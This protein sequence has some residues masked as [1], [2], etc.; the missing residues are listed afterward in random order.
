VAAGRPIQLKMTRL[1]AEGDPIPVTLRADEQGRVDVITDSTQDIYGG[2]MVFR[3]TCTGP[4]QAP[5]VLG[6]THCSE[7]TPI[8]RPGR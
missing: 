2:Q 3:Q 1:T 7:P 6:F 5:R 8:P 4:F